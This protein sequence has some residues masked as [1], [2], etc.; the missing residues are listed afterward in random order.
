MQVRLLDEESMRAEKYDRFLS[1]LSGAR[2]EFAPN[3][4]IA[5]MTYQTYVELRNEHYSRGYKRTIDSEHDVV[6]D[7]GDDPFGPPDWKVEFVPGRP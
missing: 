7:C 5:K 4:V 3:Y 6:I 1:C 2:Q